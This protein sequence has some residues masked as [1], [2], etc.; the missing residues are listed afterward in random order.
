MTTLITIEQL[1][2]LY[3]LGDDYSYHDYQYTQVLDIEVSMHTPLLY[4]MITLEDTQ[5]T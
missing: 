2:E 3:L 1:S 4:K 5:V